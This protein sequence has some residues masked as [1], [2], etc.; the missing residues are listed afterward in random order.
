[1]KYASG[2]SVVALILAGLGASAPAQ[3][4]SAPAPAAAAAS[5]QP[6][7]GPP[8]VMGTGST[9]M[10]TNPKGM[11]LYYQDRDA[12]GKSN[13]SG[14]CELRWPPLTASAADKPSGKWTIITRDDGLQ[15]AYDGK[16]VYGWI[17]DKAPGDTT[18]DGVPAASPVWHVA[19][20]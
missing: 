2:F 7:P 6:N 1:M 5:V 18:G 15:W 8:K 12:P 14:P 10:L 13:C 20:P 11:T 4:Q 9:A 17:G 19:R 16:P 3:A